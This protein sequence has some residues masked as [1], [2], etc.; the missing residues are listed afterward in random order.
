MCRLELAALSAVIRLTGILVATLRLPTHLLRLTM[1]T[2]SIPIKEQVAKD[3]AVLTSLDACITAGR[4]LIADSKQRLS[5]SV[6][7]RGSE[8]LIS[9]VAGNSPPAEK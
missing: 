7:V 4:K 3:Q 8:K 2:E 5:G 1:T 6:A 9:Q